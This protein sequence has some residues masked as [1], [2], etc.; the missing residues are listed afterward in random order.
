MT[1]T[2]YQLIAEAFSYLYEASTAVNII[3]DHPGGKQVIKELHTNRKLPHDVSWVQISDIRWSEF[4]ETSYGVILGLADQGTVAIINRGSS[5]YRVIVS[6]GDGI[7]QTVESHGGRLKE[8]V[9]MHVG[10]IRTI[11]KSE[12]Q[13]PFFD[14]S[15]KQD[16]R[17]ELKQSVPRAKTIVERLRP[18]FLKTTQAAIADLKGSIITMIKNDAFEKARKKMRRVDKLTTLLD[19]TSV[20]QAG[21]YESSIFRDAI[22]NAVTLAGLHLYPEDDARSI[23]VLKEI[24]QGNMQSLSTVL[25]YFKITLLRIS[26]Y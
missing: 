16:V 15:R 3:K 12:F 8:F 23:R 11:Y 18:L 14:L 25:G 17:K 22:N 10:K 21:F 26:Q 24:N 5:T 4:K 13:R 2:G 1:N 6:N 20:S 19:R 7:E 9:K